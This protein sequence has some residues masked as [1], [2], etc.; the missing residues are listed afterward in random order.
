MVV[1]FHVC[2][3]CISRFFIGGDLVLVFGFVSV[4]CCP[5]IVYVFCFLVF[6]FGFF[7][8][9]LSGSFGHPVVSSRG[10]LEVSEVTGNI[11]M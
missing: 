2:R 11:G 6:F 9:F 3:F 8:S 7:V 10:P 4:F 1:S 5:F